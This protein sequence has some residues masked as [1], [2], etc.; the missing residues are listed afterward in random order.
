MPSYE[1][2][3]DAC[4]IR[5]SLKRSIHEDTLPMCCGMV[6]RQ[7]YYAPGVEFRGDGWDGKS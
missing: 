3:C 7:I 5:L 6:M 1:Y 2:T 4:N